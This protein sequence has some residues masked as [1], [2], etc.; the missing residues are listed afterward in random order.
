MPEEH[1][2]YRVEIPLTLEHEIGL[3]PERT[4]EHRLMQIRA[5]RG[6]Q[7]CSSLFWVVRQ[8]GLLPEHSGHIYSPQSLQLALECIGEIGQAV[9]DSTSEQVERLEQLV[10][11][12]GAKK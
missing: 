4:P 5:V 2:A 7:L 3:D 9:A 12:A 6:L 10:V 8:L 11:K 1:P